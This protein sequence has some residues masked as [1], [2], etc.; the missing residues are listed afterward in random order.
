MEDPPRSNDSIAERFWSRSQHRLLQLIEQLARHGATRLHTLSIVESYGVAVLITRIAWVM[1]RYCQQ[2]LKRVA[3]VYDEDFI[4]E[5]RVLWLLT[6]WPRMEKFESASEYSDDA[7]HYIGRGW[8]GTLRSLRLT[9]P[10][11]QHGNENG[12]LLGL[13]HALERCTLLEELALGPRSQL[14]DDLLVAWA[15]RSNFGSTG[16]TALLLPHLRHIELHPAAPL[17]TR[18]FQAL[19]EICPL[20]TSITIWSDFYVY[21]PDADIQDTDAYD[22]YVAMRDAV[23]AMFLAPMALSAGTVAAMKEVGTR[24]RSIAYAPPVQVEWKDVHERPAV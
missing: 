22:E 10:A 1:T 8:A 20:L 6:T 15:S 11:S 4:N 24:K 23:I 21:R 9:G 2:S 3:V 14:T 5:D 17:T 18:G 16:D 19:R 12:S 13:R 7:L